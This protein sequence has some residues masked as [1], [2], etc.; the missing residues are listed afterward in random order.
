MRKSKVICQRKTKTR[1]RTKT[2]E[3]DESKG[4]FNNFRKKFGLRSDKKIGE[5]SSADQ[6]AADELPNASKT[7]FE[8]R[9]YLAEPVF[10]A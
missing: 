7:I 10:N 4:W 1:W 8:E 6:E 2:G 3:F 5:A 9:G